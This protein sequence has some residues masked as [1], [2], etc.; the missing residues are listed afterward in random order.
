MGVCKVTSDNFINAEMVYNKYYI[1]KAC[2][3]NPFTHVDLEINGE[4]KCFWRG[5]TSL[6]PNHTC[7][8][9]KIILLHDERIF[10]VD[11]IK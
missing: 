6:D 8:Q 11:D 2:Y 4:W 7:P 1:Y 9:P 3:L 10:S 5:F